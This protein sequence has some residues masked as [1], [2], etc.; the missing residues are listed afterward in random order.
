MKTY[1]VLLKGDT[2]GKITT[3]KTENLIIDSVYTVSLHDCN[4]MPLNKTGIVTEILE[5]N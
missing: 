5:V 1:T 2:V 3:D 4:G